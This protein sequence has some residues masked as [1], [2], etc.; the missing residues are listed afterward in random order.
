V[1]VC[2]DYGPNGR[3]VQAQTTIGERKREHHVRADT[4]LDAFVALR[5]TRDATSPCRR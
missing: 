5:T 2:H 4:P 1:F 3:A